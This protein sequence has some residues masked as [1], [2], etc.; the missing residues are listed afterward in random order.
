MAVLFLDPLVRPPPPPRRGSSPLR[1]ASAPLFIM[2]ETQLPML[3]TGG[4][5]DDEDD[6]RTSEV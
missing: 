1:R 2:E 4:V 3:P 5:E 6:G